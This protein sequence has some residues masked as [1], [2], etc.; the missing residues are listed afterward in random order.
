[1][2]LSHPLSFF[3]IIGYGSGADDQGDTASYPW[4]SAAVHHPLEPWVYDTGRR[5]QPPLLLSLHR[6]RFLRGL[7]VPQLDHNRHQITHTVHPAS[8][9]FATGAF[10]DVWRYLLPHLRAPVAS[11]GWQEETALFSHFSCASWGGSLQT[12]EHKRLCLWKYF[13]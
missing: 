1:M 11:S 8:S 9:I 7:S 3:S 2:H 12:T 6:W 13:Q 5:P 4:E 10:W